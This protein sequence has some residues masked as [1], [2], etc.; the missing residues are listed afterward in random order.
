MLT[1][2]DGT[3]KDLLTLALENNHQKKRCGL[4]WMKVRSGCRLLQT[5]IADSVIILIQKTGVEITM[6]RAAR[7]NFFHLS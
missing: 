3:N 1:N 5:K 4:D 6:N 2:I 7:I